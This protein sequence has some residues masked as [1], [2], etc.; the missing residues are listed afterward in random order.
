M[1]ILRCFWNNLKITKHNN[2][3]ENRTFYWSVSGDGSLTP[4][5]AYTYTSKFLI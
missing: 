4:R 2:L 5:E 1:K 3:Y